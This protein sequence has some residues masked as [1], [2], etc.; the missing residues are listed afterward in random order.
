MPRLVKGGKYVYGWSKIYPKGKII[1]P[2]EA[3]EEYGFQTGENILL[4][5]GSKTSGGFSITS[6]RLLEKSPLYVF[7]E[8]MPQI[9]DLRKNEGMAIEHNKRF[10]SRTKMQEGFIA[11]P[12]KTLA[13]YGS[14]PGNSLLSVRGSGL[15]LSFLIKGPLYE[16]AQKHENIT[17]F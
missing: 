15:A 10:F 5:S 7:L 12:S 9:A 8:E 17:V 16:L 11:V 13:C 4:M 3:L 14:R 1:I 2:H 6:S